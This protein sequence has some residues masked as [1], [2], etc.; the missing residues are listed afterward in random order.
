MHPK[1][2]VLLAR[3]LQ[4][5]GFHRVGSDA[6]TPFKGRIVAATN[7]DLDAALKS[8]KLRADLFY[9]LQ[10]AQLTIPALRDRAADIIPLTQKFL[11][12]YG[13]SNPLAPFSLTEAAKKLGISRTT[14]WKRRRGR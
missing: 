3:A 2:Q 7:A 6:F 13:S 4:D 9:R 14:L 5:G 1:M 10:N 12:A 8:G 11:A